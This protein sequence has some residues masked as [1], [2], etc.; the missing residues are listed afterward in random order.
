VGE[1]HDGVSWGRELA[2]PDIGNTGPQYPWQISGGVCSV[3]LPLLWVAQQ[4]VAMD[5]VASRR[6]R[7]A[8]V[9]I[10]CSIRHTS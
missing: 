7:S 3:C 4:I 5:C 2:L 1:H 9:I 10:P 8:D 6:H